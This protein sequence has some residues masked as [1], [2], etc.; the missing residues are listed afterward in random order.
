M[1]IV[2]VRVG[3]VTCWFKCGSRAVTCQLLCSVCSKVLRLSLMCMLLT[4][5]YRAV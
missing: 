4:I 1:A 3:A 2:R 5:F